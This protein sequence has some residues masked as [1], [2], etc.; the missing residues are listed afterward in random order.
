VENVIDKSIA[1]NLTIAPYALT[2]IPMFLSSVT[3]FR[4][5]TLNCMECGAEFLERNNDTI[6]RLNDTS[7][8]SEVA[9]NGGVIEAL[10]GRC[11]QHYH[12]MIATDVN[13]EENGIPM[14]LQPQSVYISVEN[15]KKLRYLHCMECGKAFHS[16]SDRIRQVVDNRVPFEYL[17]P[18]KIGVFEALCH[19][20]N[21]GQTWALML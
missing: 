7:Q 3:G 20:Q 21:C 11:Q 14:Y 1:I 6:Y 4:Y 5:R 15:V 12:V 10:C 2:A 8:P 13:L 16:I 18:T 9:I 17:D 19:R